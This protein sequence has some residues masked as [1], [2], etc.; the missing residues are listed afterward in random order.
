MVGGGGF[1]ERLIRSVKSCLKKN[2]LTVKLTHD[3]L[4]TIITEIEAVLNSRPLTYLYADSLEEPLT[5]SHLL[6]GRRIL[7]LPQYKDE[8]DQDFNEPA[9]GSRKRSK[10]LKQILQHYWRRWKLEYLVDL[11]EYHR[12]NNKRQNLPEIQQGDVATIEDENKKNRTYWRLGR[13]EHVIKGHD[14]VSRGARV[15]L[16]NGNFI[17]RPLQ[18]LYPLEIQD[19]VSKSEIELSHQPNS[20]PVNT[21]SR[22]TRK[23]ATVATE[24]IKIINQLENDQSTGLAA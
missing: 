18:K 9:D 10:Y 15:K 13:I 3:E 14:G 22:P 2:L 1:Y 12:M 19:K 21:L 20:I 17:E 6:V 8:E 7:G 5:P 23:A 24:S 4:N 16:A 11:R